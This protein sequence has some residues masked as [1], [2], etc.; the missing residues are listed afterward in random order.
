MKRVFEVGVEDIATTDDIFYSSGRWEVAIRKA[1]ESHLGLEF[2][3]LT[4][5]EVEK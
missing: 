1:L 5:Q 4:V 3:R 2:H